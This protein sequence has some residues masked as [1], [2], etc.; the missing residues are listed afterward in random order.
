M[1]ASP[2]WRKRAVRAAVKQNVEVA[3]I[4]LDDVIVVVSPMAGGERQRGRE[5]RIEIFAD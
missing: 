5:K 3:A 1:G 2:P 4:D